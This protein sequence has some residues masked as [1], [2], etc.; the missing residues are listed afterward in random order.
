MALR[1]H[2]KTN[3]QGDKALR[4]VEEFTN[5][6]KRIWLCCIRAEMEKNKE[7]FG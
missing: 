2:L 7:V 3:R 6:E 4:T 5:L 1:W